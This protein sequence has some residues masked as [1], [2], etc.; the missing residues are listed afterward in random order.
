MKKLLTLPVL[1]MTLVFST[2]SLTVHAVDY[3]LE[4][5][6]QIYSQRAPQGAGLE[7]S[8][9]SANMYG[10]LFKEAVEMGLDDAYQ[11]Q[12]KVYQAKAMYYFAEH[13]QDLELKKSGHR[14]GWDYGIDAAKLL[15]VPGQ[16]TELKDPSN[17]RLLA[18]SYYWQGANMG[19]W[20]L[21][22]GILNSLRQWPELRETMNYIKVLGEQ[23]VEYY[24]ANR[25]LGWAYYK[26]PFPLGDKSMAFDLLKAAHDKT[27]D[28]TGSISTHSTN[29][30]YL[31]QVLIYNGEEAQARKILTKLVEMGSDVTTATR[32]NEERVPETLE[33]IEEA[34]ALLEKI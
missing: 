12:M 21:A 3:T 17:K 29:V 14:L 1:F 25:I 20:G 15:V 26:L 33:E 10:E 13:T 4:D 32:Y 11:A 18:E 34:K 6:H 7:K 24:G 23:D 22:N 9:Q 28:S 27:L 8:R 30:L 31:A 5:A 16:T 2:F 19:K